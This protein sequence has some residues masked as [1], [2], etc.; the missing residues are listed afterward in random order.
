MLCSFIFVYTVI[1]ESP[2]IIALVD[3]TTSTFPC[4]NQPFICIFNVHDLAGIVSVL[5]PS[6]SVKPSDQYL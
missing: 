1:D 2:F 4:Y 6:Q 3:K 5:H